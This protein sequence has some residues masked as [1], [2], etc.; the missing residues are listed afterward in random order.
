MNPST[1]AVPG[2]CFNLWL[3]GEL[4]FGFKDNW[5]VWCSQACGL[6]AQ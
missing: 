3:G 2:A 6:R 5:A 4:D 1:T